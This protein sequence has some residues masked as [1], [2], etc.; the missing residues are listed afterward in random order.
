MGD[1]RCGLIDLAAPMPRPGAAGSQKI[2]VFQQNGG[3]ASKIQGIIRFGEGFFNLQTVSI[4]VALPAV[5]DDP[6]Q[7]LPHDIQAD[8][9]LDFLRHP[10]LSEDL[11]ALCCTKGIPVVASG[12]KV[13]VKGA[14]TPPT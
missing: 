9:V 2:L 4:D 12:K 1:R 3:G 6:E 5:I 10:D 14:L 11:A 13:R 7:Y 8:L